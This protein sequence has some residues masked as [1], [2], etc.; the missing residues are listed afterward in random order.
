MPWQPGVIGGT[1]IKMDQQFLF[2]ADQRYEPQSFQLPDGGL[3][4]VSDLRKAEHDTQI[5]VMCHWFYATF[6]DPVENTPYDSG[7]GGYQYIW[8]GP[9]D[10]HEELSSKF[11][12]VV[13]DEVIE[14]LADKL[15]NI[16]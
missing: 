9:Y 3:I 6:Q 15:S 2:D 10:P 11:G 12:G 7:E 14:E 8:G 4:S 5:A 1:L 16:S 13:P